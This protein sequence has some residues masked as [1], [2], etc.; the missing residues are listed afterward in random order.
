MKH[1]KSAAP[2]AVVPLSELIEP[3]NIP[4]NEPSFIFNLPGGGRQMSI[5][6]YDMTLLYQ[7]RKLPV[8]TRVMLMQMEDAELEEY[9]KAK[10]I[11]ILA[12]ARDIFGSVWYYQE[13]GEVMGPK[14][15]LMVF[16]GH[17]Q[18]PESILKLLK[19]RT[20][21]KKLSIAQL[22]ELI[23]W[24]KNDRSE[25]YRKEDRE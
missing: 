8:E 22:E 14:D 24:F 6:P 10:R 7:L 18:T 20:G 23:H 15:V 5:D 2:A 4:L 16:A 13:T 1:K 3:E 11:K 19:I 17:L 25:V 12:R 21:S 9:L